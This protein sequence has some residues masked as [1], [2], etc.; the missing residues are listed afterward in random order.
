MCH[1]SWQFVN[2]R[3]G[4][5]HDGIGLL[6]LPYQSGCFATKVANDGAASGERAPRYYLITFAVIGLRAD[7]RLPEPNLDDV[8]RASNV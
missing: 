5:K 2:T 6:V 8:S 3:S 4:G 7:E 1:A